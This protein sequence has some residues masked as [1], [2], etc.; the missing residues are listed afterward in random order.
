M[1]TKS[2]PMQTNITSTFIFSLKT[3][4]HSQNCCSFIVALKSKEIRKTFQ[5]LDSQPSG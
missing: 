1:Q 3:S 5:P 2:N 4:I